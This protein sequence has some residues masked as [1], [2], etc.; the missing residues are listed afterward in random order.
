MLENRVKIT[1]KIIRTVLEG[2]L[3]NERKA[4]IALTLPGQFFLF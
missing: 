2:V 3:G 4:P 1:I